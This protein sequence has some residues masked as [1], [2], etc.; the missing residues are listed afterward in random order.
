M[1]IQIYQK[2][3]VANPWT[4]LSL[5]KEE[6]TMP[7]QC[8]RKQNNPCCLDRQE[9]CPL[10]SMGEGYQWSWRR[11]QTHCGPSLRAA[12]TWACNFF[13]NGQ[14]EAAFASPEGGESSHNSRLA[15]LSLAVNHEQLSQGGKVDHRLVTHG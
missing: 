9:G 6:Q 2:R 12:G 7:N 4:T 5:P 14:M 15:E 3:E 13:W 11:T 10:A 1:T 8:L